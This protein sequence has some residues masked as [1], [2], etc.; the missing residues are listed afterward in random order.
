MIGDTLGTD[1]AGANIAG[2]DSALVLGRN[3]KEDEL[4][5]DIYALGV[6]PTYILNDFCK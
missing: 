1:I 5:D 4:R 2:I 3:V 6:S